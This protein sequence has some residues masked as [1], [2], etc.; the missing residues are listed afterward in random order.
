MLE[1]DARAG[2]CGRREA[3]STSAREAWDSGSHNGGNHGAPSQQQHAGPRWQLPA[4]ASL[5]GGMG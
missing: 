3:D 2:K 5:T 1:E 4:K